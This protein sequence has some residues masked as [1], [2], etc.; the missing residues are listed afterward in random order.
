MVVAL[1]K[2]DIKSF[3]KI[4]ADIKPVKLFN[5]LKFAGKISWEEEPLLYQKRV[6]NEWN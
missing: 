5:S 4:I 1:E 2:N 6:R 3:D